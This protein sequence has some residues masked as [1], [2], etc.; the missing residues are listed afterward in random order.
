M[1]TVTIATSPEV[2]IAFDGTTTE[3][4]YAL[5]IATAGVL[6]GI[7]VG[8]NLTIDPVTGILD[9]TGGGG[10]TSDH[11]LLTNI[12][13]NTHGQIDSFITATNG[14]LAGK[15]NNITLTTTGSS[16]VATLVG[17]TLNIPN[18]V[19][20]G[21]GGGDVFLASNNLFT[22]GQ[23]VALVGGTHDVL[24]IPTVE[25]IGHFYTTLDQS[26][27]NGDGKYDNVLMTGYN[28]NG[29]GGRVNTDEASIHWALES[30]YQRFV[31]ADPEFEVHLQTTNTSGLLT[32]R[33][34]SANISK[35]SGNA[36][37]FLQ[38]DAL[39]FFP[40][41]VHIDS[42]EAFAILNKT[43]A[44]TLA[45]PSANFTMYGGTAGIQ[46]QPVDDGNGQTIITNLGAGGYPSIVLASTMLFT[47]PAPF[48]GTLNHFT[49]N[50]TAGGQWLAG[51]DYQGDA[52]FRIG[53]GSEL[54][55]K[56]GMGAGIRT[57]NVDQDGNITTGALA[58]TITGSNIFTGDNYFSK[59][60]G[61]SRVRIESA[62]AGGGGYAGIDFINNAGL[63]G[64]FVGTSTTFS[65]AS[66][67]LPSS[68]NLAS[69]GVGGMGFIN[70]VGTATM[71]WYIGAA[72]ADTDEKLR[73][74]PN[75]T[76]NAYADYS[77]NYTSRS[78]IDKGYLDTRLAAFNPYTDEMAQDAV[79][80]ILSSEFSYVDA[81]PVIS[82]NAIAQSKITSLVADLALKADLVDGIVPTGQLPA[83]IVGILFYANFAALPGTGAANTIY[84]TTDNS[85]RWL[86]T[87]AAY[88]EIGATPPVLSVNALTGDV[89]LTPAIIGSP[90][91]ARTIT[92]NGTAFDLSANR[93]W[94]VGTVTSLTVASSNGFA[95]SFTSTATPVLTISTSVTGILKGNG[96]SVAAAIAADFPTLNQDTAGTAANITGIAAIANGGTG[97]TAAGAAFNALSPVTLLGDLIYGSGVNTN[98]RLAGN[99]SLTKKFLVQTGA[100]GTSA[101]PLWDVIIAGDVPTLNQN[102]TGTAVNITGVLNAGSFPAL[103]GDVTSP[104]GS[105]TTTI[106]N[107]AL[108]K[109]QQISTATILGRVTAATGAIEQ[110]NGTQATTLLDVF[111]TAFKGV[112]PASGGGSTNFLRAD[113]TWGVPPGTGAPLASPTFTGTVTTPLI[114]ITS[115]VPGVGKVLT[116][117]ADGDATWETPAGGGFTGGTL[118]S[119]LTL[120]AGTATAA[121]S[122]LKFQTGAL[123]TTPEAGAFEYLTGVPYFTPT[124]GKRGIIATD[125]ISTIQSDF[126]LAAASGVQSCF[127][128]THDVITLEASTTYDF[129]GVYI[130]N[131]GTT[132]HTTAMAFALGGG[133]TVTSVEYLATLWSAAANTIATASSNVHVSGVASK[134]LNATSTA[135]YTIIRFQGIW[136]QNVAGTVT[137]QINFSA[138]PTGTNL[139]KVGSY[140]K[141][142]PKGS[143]T[144]TFVGPWS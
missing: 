2:E 86:W 90:P 135:V 33:L 109:I 83:S 132:T 7:K 28:I 102:T 15:Q 25:N 23:T 104:G 50:A 1:T 140:I 55:W 141:F 106:A 99:T 40:S 134:V 52:K 103:A 51:F 56:G 127:T 108:S 123:N 84:V 8:E 73:L 47:S 41:G 139:M 126:T 49:F 125:H 95:G 46:I 77:S 97:Q 5:P 59:A 18:Y 22:T 116:S 12:G 115:G 21:G 122:P 36:L 17:S 62:D 138:S 67:F 80:T 96:T 133:A 3:N 53:S 98:A 58:A 10:G 69:Y 130:I 85:K 35:A 111:T 74:N 48:A 89:V 112:A 118:T 32:Q 82:I 11:T 76:L 20:G 124:A 110:L 16:G 121:T 81:T 31:D 72:F 54:W 60:S 91:D 131:T 19:G 71:R 70:S 107:L 42:S 14:T 39:Q 45:G 92:I 143:N 75:G 64:Q 142:S 68:L 34:F 43:G 93:S 105:L 100:G 117:D 37:M 113:G 66:V 101:A 4:P 137:P 94:S 128:A 87:G 38:C 144:M 61:A 78:Y 63:L 6:G 136:R 27:I 30:H 29:A 57:M 26:Y 120:A 114:K 88:T 129:E 79:G 24:K 13:T 119:N 65:N 9:A 44:F